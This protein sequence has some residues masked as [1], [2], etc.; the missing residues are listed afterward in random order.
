MLTF[1][2]I[3]L[4]KKKSFHSRLVLILL[5]NYVSSY[6]TECCIIGLI[7]YQFFVKPAVFFWHDISPDDKCITGCILD[8]KTIRNISFCIF[9]QDM[10]SLCSFLRCVL[11]METL[12]TGVYV[13]LMRL[14]TRISWKR[15]V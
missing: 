4:K 2:F 6:V 7:Y 11:R 8:L 14:K 15:S 10:L 3:D 12:V 1:T 9:W 5:K 13:I